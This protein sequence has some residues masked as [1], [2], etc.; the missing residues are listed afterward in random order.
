MGICCPYI[1]FGF[2]VRQ[3]QQATA[4]TASPTFPAGA[5][6]GLSEVEVLAAASLFLSRGYCHVRTA[7][8]CVT[9]FRS[10]EKALGTGLI[11]LHRGNQLAPFAVHKN[12]H[13]NLLKGLDA[14][15]G[16]GNSKSVR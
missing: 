10:C 16:E 1:M 11:F 15:S 12:G 13:T 5:R 6:R 2:I 14:G 8:S 7:G 4:L 3:S 9:F